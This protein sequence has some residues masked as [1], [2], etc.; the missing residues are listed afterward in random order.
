MIKADK[1]KIALHHHFAAL[2]HGLCVKAECFLHLQAAAFCVFRCDH[3]INNDTGIQT[4]GRLSLSTIN[5]K[6]LP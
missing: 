4:P 5:P 2:A 3:F 1:R 6:G